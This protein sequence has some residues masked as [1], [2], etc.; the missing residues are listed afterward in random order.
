MIGVVTMHPL[1]KSNNFI[2]QAV[3]ELGYTTYVIDINNDILNI[4]KN[5]NITHWIFSGSPHAVNDE[6]SPQIPL[7]ILNL[8]NK[9]IMFICYSMESILYQKGY[10]IYRR[11]ENK[12]EKFN[13]KLDI[14][15]IKKINKNY[16]FEGLPEKLHVYRNHHYYF[17]SI[18]S[19][20]FIEV[21]TYRGESMICF[22]KNFI[23]LQFHPERT[24]DGKK[25]INN[26][27]KN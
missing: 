22:Y 7:E 15:K 2:K 9:K 20:E 14:N 6:A 21:A 25:I 19:N 17:K 18:K 13:L 27:I 8:T 11:Y 5:S 16:L 12:K 4:I 26:W 23:L 24:D 1:I 10:E 3:E